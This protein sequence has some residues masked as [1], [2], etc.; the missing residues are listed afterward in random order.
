MPYPL[1]K[2]PY[3]LRRRLRKLATPGEA[4]AFQIA[5]PN[6][7][8][9]QPIQRVQPIN[10]V[11]FKIDENSNLLLR[12]RKTLIDL[13]EDDL[14]QICDT[15]SITNFKLSDSSQLILDRA[16]LAPVF[17]DFCNC[18]INSTFIRSLVSRMQQQVHC[19]C[20]EN[21]IIPEKKV[22]KIVC[23]ANAFKSL[24]S[25]GLIHSKTSMASWIDGF[26]EAKISTIQEFLVSDDSASVFKINKI[27][28]LEFYKA[29]HY[30]FKM[31][32]EM[33]D[34]I[35][36]TEK[37]LKALF[38]KHFKCLPEKPRNVHKFVHVNRGSVNRYYVP[39]KKVYICDE[40]DDDDDV[41]FQ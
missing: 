31:R 12:H 19:L 27:K 21:C 39:K 28:F 40:D 18:I 30:K 35:V 41:L 34:R 29:Q 4:Y 7:S 17:V 3:G 26:L 2:L 20:F 6:Y 9:L 1:E 22:A 38:G 13:Q 36:K 32:I 8:G 24:T 33:S 10:R 15:I 23:N 14:F 16:V 37:Q 5:A 11:K 25:F